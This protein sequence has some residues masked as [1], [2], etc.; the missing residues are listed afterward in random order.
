MDATVALSIFC[1]LAVM[2]PYV[3]KSMLS[4]HTPRQMNPVHTTIPYN[5]R[6]ILIL[7]S[8]FMS[9][10]PKVVPSLQGFQLKFWINSSAQHACILHLI[11]LILRASSYSWMALQP[12]W[13]LASFSVSWSISSTIGRTPWMSDQFIARPLPKFWTGNGR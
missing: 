7:S 4:D 5:L 10:F 9:I 13:V 12:L 3:Y 8:Y 1:I 11:I 2:S 6:S